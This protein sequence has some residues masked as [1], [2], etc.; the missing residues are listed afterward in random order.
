MSDFLEDLVN[1]LGSDFASVASDGLGAAEFSGC[2]DTGCY[3]FNAAL[4]GSLYGGLPN[5]KITA[6]A[7]ESSTGKSFL[8]LGIVKHFLNADKKAYVVYFDTEAAITKD[9]LEEREIDTK[10]VLIVEPDT[11][12][13]FRTKA[14]K[15]L[16][17][18]EK[19]KEEKRGPLLMVLDSL[20]MLSTTKELEDTAEGKE[21]RDMT[22]AQVIKAT[23]R[24]LTL[25]LAR[26]R[27]PMIVTNH[28]YA[29][30][31]SMFP[32]NEISGGSGLKYSAS[33]IV[34]LGKAKDKDGTEVV[35]NFI[36]CKMFKSRLSKENT[37][38]SL[39]L[40]Y[41]TGLDKHYGLLDL[42]E[43]HGIFKKSG[44]KY[45]LPDSTKVFGNKINKE[46]ERYFTAEIMEKLEKAANK[47]FKY[48]AVDDYGDLGTERSGSD[49]EVT[50]SEDSLE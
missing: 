2:I 17:T 4:S 25:R 3:I 18:Y 38:V 50:D 44:N 6:I 12:Q 47:Q 7:G 19:Q 31:G 32:S 49:N 14:I 5:N 40:S 24:V 26:A 29:A 46:P 21:T 22:K 13:N 15:I 10:R 28:V 23:F 42:A 11:I 9:M 34:M 8:A 39:K 35:G 45:E 37:L 48:G 1:E 16:D 33:S 30:V 27:V 36:R 43:K 41:K 20:G